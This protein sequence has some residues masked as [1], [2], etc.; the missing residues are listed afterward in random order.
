VN[1]NHEATAVP[2]IQA[3]TKSATI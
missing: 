1:N 3:S 2:E